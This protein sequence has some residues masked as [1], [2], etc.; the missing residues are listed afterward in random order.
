MRVLQQ[1]SAYDQCR[2]TAV[3]E[4]VA[5]IGSPIVTALASHDRLLVD[6]ATR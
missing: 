5:Q 3:G 2:K 4:A 1:R 6:L